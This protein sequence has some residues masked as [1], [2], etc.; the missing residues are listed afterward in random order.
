MVGR[1]ADA[2]NTR[3]S[4]MMTTNHSIANP[5]YSPDTDDSASTYTDYQAVRYSSKLQFGDVASTHD[6][7]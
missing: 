2:P 6:A 4:T 7:V 3:T 5:L 1:V